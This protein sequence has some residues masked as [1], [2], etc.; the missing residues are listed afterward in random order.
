MDEPCKDTKI[1]FQSK[2]YSTTTSTKSKSSKILRYNPT[3][4]FLRQTPNS[5]ESIS[6]V[7]VS[8]N[9]LRKKLPFSE[10][11]LYDLL[12]HWSSL[13]LFLFRLCQHL[14]N[15]SS[16]SSLI[17]KSSLYAHPCDTILI[18]GG[19]NASVENASNNHGRQV[20]QYIPSKN[21]WNFVSLMPNTRQYHSAV[22]F[23]GRVY[24]AGGIVVNQ[25][26]KVCYHQ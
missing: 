20:F 16:V 2:N 13:I 5:Q 11:Q 12:L 26:R 25:P 15:K 23:Q 7:N 22:I 19:L 24:I 8:G 10:F 14:P 1:L 17:F 9:Y 21:R 18:F 6:S 4:N 3:K